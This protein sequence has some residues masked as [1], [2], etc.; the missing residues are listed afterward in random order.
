[1]K[2]MWEYNYS[3]SDELY[4][5]GVKGMKWYIRRYQNPDGSLTE[6]GRRREAKEYTKK[7]RDANKKRISYL[8]KAIIN[9]RSAGYKVD[10]ANEVGVK[11][12]LALK[13]NNIKKYERLRQKN[14]DLMKSAANYTI[15][16]HKA[17]AESAKYDKLVNKIVKELDSKGYTI[18]TYTPLFSDIPKQKV[19]EKK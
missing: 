9:N 17:A 13:K 3:R 16:Q 18:K 12:G 7:Y 8:S 1:M 2:I 15:E 5:Y 11:A 6:A 14:L 4:H 10:L 19:V